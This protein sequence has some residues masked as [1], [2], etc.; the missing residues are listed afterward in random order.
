[1]GFSKDTPWFGLLTVAVVM[2]AL[3]ASLI[4][5][6]PTK[7]PSAALG[8]D[9]VL[10]AERIVAILAAY[11]LLALVIARSWRGQLPVELSGRGVKYADEVKNTSSRA[12]RSLITGLRAEQ[13]ARLELEDRVDALEDEL[14]ER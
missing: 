2:F 12:L 8:S 13:T 9:V 3:V 5:G 11:L 7:L 1:M 10:H 6:A 4:A 14:E